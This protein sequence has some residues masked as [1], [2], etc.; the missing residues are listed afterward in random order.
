MNDELSIDNLNIM[1]DRALKHDATFIGVKIKMQGF[2]KPEIIINQV[3]NFKT[4]LEYYNKAYNRNLTLK[5]FN[6]IK[7]IGF[8][9]AYSYEEIEKILG[10][11]SIPIEN[12]YTSYYDGEEIYNI[13]K[14]SK[15]I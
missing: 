3:E 15:I 1:V 8:T 12:D 4:K 6:G 2:E 7:I 14:G 5:A 13:P 11:K 10:P 9:F